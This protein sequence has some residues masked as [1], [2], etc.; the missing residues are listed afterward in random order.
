[1]GNRNIYTISIDHGQLFAGYHMIVISEKHNDINFELT[2]L[3]AKG[4]KLST[5]VHLEN[6][7]VKIFVKLIL[8]RK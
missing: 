6:F 4:S 2:L 5:T 7:G 3:T 1:M 8:Q